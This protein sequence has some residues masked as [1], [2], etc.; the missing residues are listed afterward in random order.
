MQITSS[1]AVSAQQALSGQNNTTN[2]ELD[3]DAF[4]KLL[5]TQMQAQDPLNPMDNT[6][7][8]AQLS[9]FTSLER[10]EGMSQSL[11]TLAMSTA[12]NTSA[13]MVSFIGKHLDL[14][15]STLTLDP[16]LYAPN[17]HTPARLELKEDVSQVTI[18]V[19][20]AEG[21]IVRT[22]EMGRHNA[23]EDLPISWDGLDDQGAP[24]PK[25]NYSLTVE[26]LNEEGDRVDA[27]LIT[28]RR[29][30]GVSFEG[31]I[32]RLEIEGLEDEPAS[33]GEVRQVTQHDP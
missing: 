23:D 29:V 18:S 20:N 22:I 8:V 11:N 15:R 7:F 31:G 12:S 24:L 5:T 21:K 19:K 33:L 13:Q 9:Q 2:K 10:L 25:G 17:T 27:Q 16:A 6:Q 1:Q 26:A 14:P 3:R 32:P 4:L 30:T 28:T